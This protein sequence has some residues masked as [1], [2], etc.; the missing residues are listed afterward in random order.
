[1]IKIYFD[2]LTEGQIFT[3]RE[4]SQ[5]TQTQ[6][7]K[8]ISATEDYNPIYFDAEMASMYG[9]RGVYTPEQLVYSL[10]YDAINK[11]FINI[12]ILELR[13]T[14]HRLVRPHDSLKLHIAIKLKTKQ[15]TNFIVVFD[16]WAENQR[17]DIV[18]KGEAEAL[19]F[20]SS[21]SEKSA[22]NKVPSLA[23][24]IKKKRAQSYKDLLKNIQK[25][26]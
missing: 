10:I 5:I 20:K 9:Y 18:A 13:Q 7:V 25:L 24:E 14:F 23:A 6:I 17:H 12:K 2:S 26:I 4:I 21:S 19:V 8:F 16:L 1:M 15:A 22:R 3:D 11:V